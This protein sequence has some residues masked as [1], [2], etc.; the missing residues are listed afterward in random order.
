MAR[1]EEV[2]DQRSGSRELSIEV[3]TEIIPIYAMLL[4]II[5]NGRVAA[6][7]R[8]LPLLGTGTDRGR[9]YTIQYTQFAWDESVTIRK[10]KIPKRS[11]KFL[12]AAI[13]HFIVRPKTDPASSEEKAATKS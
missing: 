3:T 2:C 10:P 12:N 6:L 1:N 13:Q 7:E 9:A 4:E 11:G 5:I 8:P